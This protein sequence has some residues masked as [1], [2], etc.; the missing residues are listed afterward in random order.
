MEVAN[1]AGTNNFK[2]T[3]H[4]G[5][6]LK[7]FIC[8]GPMENFLNGNLVYKFASHL[9]CLRPGRDFRKVITPKKLP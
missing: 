8:S 7:K 2:T 9:A 5:F 1:E 4:H 3:L 6:L